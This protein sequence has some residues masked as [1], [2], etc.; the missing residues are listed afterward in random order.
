PSLVGELNQSRAQSTSIV[1]DFPIIP[2]QQKTLAIL[3]FR[4]L[5]DQNENSWSLSFLES[6]ITE[7]TKFKSLII[8]PSSYVTKY[9]NQDVNP[10]DVG[11]E[12]GADAVMI[13]SYLGPES[14]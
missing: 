10:A 2:G 11:H 5:G 6:L 3:P 7:L 1:D 14:K 4:N 9:L 13:G 8:R 12:L